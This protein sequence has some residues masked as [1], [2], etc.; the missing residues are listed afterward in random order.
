[1]AF[2]FN[3]NNQEP[4]NIESEILSELREMRQLLERIQ[5]DAGLIRDDV[6][7]ISRK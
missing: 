3:E 2:G 1:M 7:R 5:K 6:D 4:E